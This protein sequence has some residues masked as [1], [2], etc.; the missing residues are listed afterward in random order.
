MDVHE[1]ECLIS[2]AISNRPKATTAPLNLYIYNGK[3]ICGARIIMPREAVFVAYVTPDCLQNGFNDKQWKLIVEK[4]A[5]LFGKKRR[6]AGADKKQ[7][8]TGQNSSLRRRRQQQPRFKER[9]K[10]QRLRYHRHVWFGESI[11]EKPF[12]GRM[13][14][15]SSEGMAFLCR[16]DEK[17]P[18][19]EE[20]IAVRFAAP[21]LCVDGSLD[22]VSFDRISRVC[23]VEKEDSRLNRIAV[24]FAKPLPFKPAEQEL[25]QSKARKKLQTIT[26]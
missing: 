11:S 21:R 23:R 8:G 16:R 15:V 13:L 7:A 20:Q 4:A 6:S 3:L 12:K 22:D 26:A 5:R 19:A 18:A 17:N 24:Q 2:E 10:E 14:D 9:R 1:I 25:G